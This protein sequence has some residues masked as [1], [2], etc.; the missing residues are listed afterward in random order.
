MVIFPTL[1]KAVD[2]VRGAGMNAGRLGGALR[3]E[4]RLAD[5]GNEHVGTY[6]ID[7]WMLELTCCYGTLRVPLGLFEEKA[8]A[9][10]LLKHLAHKAS[11]E[12]ADQTPHPATIAATKAAAPALARK[13]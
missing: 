5:H 11:R 12:V 3:H 4:V 2:S 9:R 10:K 8:L 6:R 1:I 13:G 7:G